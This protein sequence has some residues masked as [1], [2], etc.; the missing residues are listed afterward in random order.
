[1]RWYFKVFD[2]SPLV[3]P[4]VINDLNRNDARRIAWDQR[5]V[6][7]RVQQ[8]HLLLRPDEHSTRGRVR[9]SRHFRLGS[10]EAVRVL[11]VV[12]HWTRHVWL[13]LNVQEPN[14]L[15]GPVH[16]SLGL[17]GPHVSGLQRRLSP[18]Y[19]VR[20]ILYHLR[21]D[22]P[23]CILSVLRKQQRKKKTFRARTFFFKK[24]PR[25]YLFFCVVIL[26]LMF[27]FI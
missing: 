18:H 2:K 19:W 12:D 6:S 14:G 16:C 26:C 9:P 13:R 22:F 3:L 10:H 25:L 4:W 27:Y 11:D 21:I 20:C 24:T 17:F 7:P 1:M 15:D 8:E 23:P 5:Q